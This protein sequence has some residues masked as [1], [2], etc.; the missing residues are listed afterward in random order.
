[1]QT[2]Y[3]TIISLYLIYNIND[4]PRSYNKIISSPYKDIQLNSIKEELEE[5]EKQKIQDI[6][7]TI[8]NN[9]AL[10]GT[11][12]VYKIKILSPFQK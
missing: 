7:S 6:V 10:L 11:R 8:P 3:L 1:M 4:E 2:D 9:R 5:L 12:Q